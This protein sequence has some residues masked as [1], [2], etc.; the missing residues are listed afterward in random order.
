[1]STFIGWN[2]KEP[3]I[4]GRML[5]VMI[6][7]LP[8]LG[9][10][11]TLLSRG[12]ILAGHGHK[13]AQIMMIVGGISCLPGILATWLPLRRWRAQIIG[14]ELRACRTFAG[15]PKQRLC[16]ID[17]IIAVYQAYRR[18]EYSS[19]SAHDEWLYDAREATWVVLL[20]ETL[21]GKRLQVIPV[22]VFGYEKLETVRDIGRQLANHLKVEF[23][24]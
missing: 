18:V 14:G 6:L 24:G 22:G 23:H 10:G 12:L 5:I 3:F 7:G 2:F 16:Y 17:N 21:D 8:M 15:Q 9:I 11:V 20:V 19:R 1:M 4:A 13:D